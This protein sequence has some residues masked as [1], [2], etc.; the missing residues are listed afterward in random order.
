[1][2]LPG[3]GKSTIVRGLVDR[4]GLRQVC[5]DAI[6]RAMFPQCDYSF[7]EKRAAFRGVLL[8]VEINGLLDKASVVDGMTFSRREDRDRLADIVRQHG[9]DLLWLLA[10][11]DPARARTRIANDRLHAMHPAL[12]RTPSLVDAMAGCFENL[13]SGVVRIDANGSAE[14]MCE[15]AI[16]AVAAKLDAGSAQV[17]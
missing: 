13:P 8:A 16:N 7:I 6:R 9:F 4:F 2:G 3:A 1:M 11:C 14:R 15:A 12:D 10:V 17:L 5:R